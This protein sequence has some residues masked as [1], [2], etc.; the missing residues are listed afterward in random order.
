MIRLATLVSN[1]PSEVEDIVMDAFEE[2]AR[3]LDEL[4]S[5]GAYLRTA[6][7]NGARRRY[8]TQ[9]RRQSIIE[10]NLITLAPRESTEGP[11]YLADVLASL[12]ERDHTILVLVYY[13]GMTP[14]EAAE[15]LELPAGTVRSAIH[16]ALARL[17]TEVSA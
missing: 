15:T 14:T 9:S 1:S 11:E 17:R 12:P 16:R 2:T 5:P 3:R 4:R 6:V 10:G 13:L 8:R 7:I